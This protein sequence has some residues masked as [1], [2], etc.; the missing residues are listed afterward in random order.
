[1]I[2]GTTGGGVVTA[3]TIGVRLQNFKSKRPPL[4]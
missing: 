2:A 3:G 4:L 1:V